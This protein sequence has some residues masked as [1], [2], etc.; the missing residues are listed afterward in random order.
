M[1]SKKKKENKTKM[2]K[3]GQSKL[4]KRPKKCPHGCHNV[5]LYIYAHNGGFLK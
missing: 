5:G 1:T 2:I 3:V 4:A